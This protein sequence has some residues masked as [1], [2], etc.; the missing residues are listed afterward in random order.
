MDGNES[1]EN[2]VEYSLVTKS[3]GSSLYTK[4]KGSLRFKGNAHP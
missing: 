3:S 2:Y 4:K 1:K